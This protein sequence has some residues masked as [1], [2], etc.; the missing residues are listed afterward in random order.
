MKFEDIKIGD[1]VT[2]LHFNRK[3]QGVVSKIT[4]SAGVVPS[5]VRK[6]IRIDLVNGGTVDRSHSDVDEYRPES[7]QEIAD[8]KIKL[9][10]A[11]QA[12]AG[13]ADL[14]SELVRQSS[15][16]DD[17][18]QALERRRRQI[19]ELLVSVEIL[20]RALVDHEATLI[21]TDIN[22]LMARAASFMDKP[23][24]L[25]SHLKVMAER[26]ASPMFKVDVEVAMEF[27]YQNAHKV[28]K[29]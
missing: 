6:S 25:F 14:K 26:Y 20:G 2:T 17:L 28:I 18:T 8:L 1:K 4:L 24:L 23:H 5:H 9:A 21:N 3:H 11:E 7:E 15:R 16:A 13:I 12:C 29:P 27:G 22:E 10:T 19:D